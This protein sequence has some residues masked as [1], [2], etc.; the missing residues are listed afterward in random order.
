[1]EGRT[2]KLIALIE[3]VI[4]FSGLA[5]TIFSYYSEKKVEDSRLQCFY[6]I[7]PD[8]YD[9][10]YDQDLNICQCIEI[11]ILGNEKISKTTY[12]G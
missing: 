4:L 6:E 7:Y 12:M 9:A 3:A 10:Y 1:M 8:C 2:W 5:L 11:D